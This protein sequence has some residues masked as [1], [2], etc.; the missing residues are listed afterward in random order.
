MTTTKQV[1][2]DVAAFLEKRCGGGRGKEKEEHRRKA[3]SLFGKF[4]ALKVH[5]PEFIL[6]RLSAGESAGFFSKTRLIAKIGEPQIL[7][8]T[9]GIPMAW[10]FVKQGGPVSTADVEKFAESVRDGVDPATRADFHDVDNFFYIPLELT[11]EL[12]NP[13]IL[14]SQSA[15]IDLET[16]IAK[17]MV[18]VRSFAENPTIIELSSTPD[19]ELLLIRGG[20]VDLIDY[21]ADNEALLEKVRKAHELV[22]NEL[23]KRG[24]MPGIVR[25]DTEKAVWSRAF[26]NDLPDSSFLFIESGGKKDGEGKTVPRSLRHFPVKDGDGKIDLP[27]LRNA[28]ARIPQSNAPGL[29]SDKKK[30]L[31]DRARRMLSET[32]K[33]VNKCDVCDRAVRIVKSA[34]TVGELSQEERFIFGVVL[35]PDE[36]DSQGDTYTALEVAKAAHAYM[37]NTDGR[38]LL[39]HAGNPVTGIKVLETYVTK[40]VETHNGETFPIGTW[41]LAA[42]VIDDML[43]DQIKKGVFTGFSIG[44][45]AIRES[46]R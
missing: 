19:E 4:P 43:W 21:E 18:D 30:A 25:G 34:V 23:R 13:V 24:V 1:L 45:S 3:A 15:T 6:A 42:R 12:S 28:I 36:V 7:V 26:I 31:Q 10:A 8:N 32:Q 5:D 14:K 37:E 16:D 2:D 35:V 44:G 38:F 17:S 29:T 39:M 11:E 46:L 9:D 40:A 27:H 41:L 20:L 22:A 33:G